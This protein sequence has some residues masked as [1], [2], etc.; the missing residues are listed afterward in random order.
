[1]AEVL[2]PV[3]SEQDPEGEGVLATWLVADGDV[4]GEG[5]LIGEVMVAK[6]SADLTAP[7]SGQVHL[8]VAEEAVVRQGQPVATVE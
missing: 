6:V 4:V 7:A 1:M 8:L 5:Q 3:L 2:F